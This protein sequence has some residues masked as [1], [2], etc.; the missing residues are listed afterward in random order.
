MGNTWSEMNEMSFPSKPAIIVIS[1]YSKVVI[2][3][4]S[5]VSSRMSVLDLD[6]REVLLE[7][8]KKS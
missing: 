6:A 4:N 5:Y 3:V 2:S 7:M 8:K 1:T